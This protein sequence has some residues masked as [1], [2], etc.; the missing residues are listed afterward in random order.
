MMPDLGK[1]A[2]HVL[3]AYGVSLGLIAVLQIMN[4]QP[5]WVIFT[6]RAA[7]KFAR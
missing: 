3:A 2:G 4:R 6:R 7:R 5:G 1:Y